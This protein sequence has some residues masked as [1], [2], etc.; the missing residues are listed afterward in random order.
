MINLCTKTGH[1]ST[2][3]GISLGAFILQ[4]HLLGM[5]RR[6]GES[7]G[8]LRISLDRSYPELVEGQAKRIPKGSC[9]LLKRIYKRQENH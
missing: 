9:L 8:K 7:F 3:N 1:L 4:I 2:A 6:S 5:V